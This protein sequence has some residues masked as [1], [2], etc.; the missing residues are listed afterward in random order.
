[1]K[2]KVFVAFVIASLLPTGIALAQ[3]APPSAR[4]DL[5]W[6]PFVST[7]LYGL[8]GILL[9]VLGYFVFDR[10]LGLDL[11]RELVEDQNQ[12][13]GIMLAGVFIGISIVVGAVMLS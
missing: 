9:A 1:M 7:I 11:K 10:I 4:Y 13:L 6:Q 12:A 3:D 5:A 8:V 2:F